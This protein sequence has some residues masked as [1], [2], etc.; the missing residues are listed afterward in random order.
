MPYEFIKQAEGENR[1]RIKVLKGKTKSNV[2]Y[3]ISGCFIW[4]IVLKSKIR[5][6]A[7]VNE[8]V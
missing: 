6:P 2:L 1:R 3:H 4:I 7:R 5:T 8:S